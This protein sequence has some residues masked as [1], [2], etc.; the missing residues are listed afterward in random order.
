VAVSALFPDI[1]N[2]TPYL[3]GAPDETHV[4]FGWTV[5]YLVSYSLIRVGLYTV[6]STGL[7]LVDQQDLWSGDLDAFFSDDSGSLGIVSFTAATDPVSDPYDLRVA[8]VRAVGDSLDISTYIL[9]NDVYSTSNSFTTFNFSQDG[10]QF[11]AWTPRPN[12]DEYFL[13]VY[14][15]ATGSLLWSEDYGPVFGTA[16]GGSDLV[17]FP[18]PDQVLVRRQYLG[19]NPYTGI[20]LLGQSGILDEITYDYDA[21]DYTAGYYGNLFWNGC[22]SA[23]A[24]HLSTTPSEQPW[25]RKVFVNDSTIY[26]AYDKQNLDIIQDDNIISVWDAWQGQ[27]CFLD[28]GRGTLIWVNSDTNESVVSSPIPDYLPYSGAFNTRGIAQVGYQ[29]TVYFDDYRVH[30]FNCVTGDV[31]IY[32][33]RMSQRNDTYGVTQRSPRMDRSGGA[34]SSSPYTSNRLYGNGDTSYI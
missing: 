18:Q 34:G 16:A 6:S 29:W 23:S 31:V 4:V 15:S 11:C 33:L 9:G 25:Y 12:S 3:I 14:S 28:R 17:G 21:Y 20:V 10:S 7:T 1:D 13:W 30:I 26:W 2:N 8:L 27:L 22:G 19:T 5:D 24:V 32:P